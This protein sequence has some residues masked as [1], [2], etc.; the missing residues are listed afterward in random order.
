M[1]SSSSIRATINKKKD[2]R[3]NLK[4]RKDDLERIR[5]RLNGEFDDDVS[6]A[7]KH[8]AETVAYLSGGLSGTSLSVSTMVCD[9]ES[10]KEQAVWSDRK[11]SSAEQSINQEISRC[12]TEIGNLDA[13]I[14]RLEAEYRAAKERERRAALAALGL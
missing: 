7:R 12:Q 5:M 6:A 4:N 11:L 13:E 2:Q 9:I 8:N 3:K 10:M 1:A 14:N